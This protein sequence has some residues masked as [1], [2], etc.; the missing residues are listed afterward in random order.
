MKRPATVARPE[1]GFTL[2]EMLVAVAVLA[3]A[4]AAILSG[5][6]RYADNTAHLRERTLALWVAH[7][8]LTE[9]ELQPKWPDVSK[10]DGDME[11]GGRSWR[12]K[13]EVKK[14]EDPHLRR[15]DI[16]VLSPNREG[17]AATLS[18]FI[19]DTGRQ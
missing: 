9:I 14:T 18:S 8:R 17:N 13:V 19:A 4:M 7:N 15:I 12:W 10:S 2:V 11:M 6:A 5:M 3:I 1:H 16:Q